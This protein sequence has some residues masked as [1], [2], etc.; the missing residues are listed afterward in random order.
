MPVSIE[1]YIS[2][3]ASKKMRRRAI[4]VWSIFALI[5]A[6]WVI[7]ILLAPYAE[8]NNLKGVS[9]SV[10]NFFGYLCHQDPARSFHFE[11]HAFAVCSRC[12]GVYFGLLLGFILYPFLRSIEETNP[13][14]RFWI[15]LALIPMAI[16][17][18]LGFFGIWENT[19][20]SRFLTG[21]IVGIACAVFIIPASVEIA[22]LLSNRKKEQRVS[23]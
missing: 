1:N 8:A 9:N 14:S 2:Q 17:W 11:T 15:F 21:L 12:F 16:D 3:T 13:L 19:H 20:F 18:S 7:L 4:F 22:Q 23:G 5:A 6:I 10:Y